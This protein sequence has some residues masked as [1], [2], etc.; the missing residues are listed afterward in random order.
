MLLGAQVPLLLLFVIVDTLLFWEQQ[1]LKKNV[2][3]Q[4]WG[5]PKYKINFIQLVF[6]HT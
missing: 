5:C 2:G 6:M 1:Q 4:F 3:K